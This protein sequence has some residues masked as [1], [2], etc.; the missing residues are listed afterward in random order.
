M[1]RRMTSILVVVVALAAVFWAVAS[2]LTRPA[3]LDETA[4]QKMIDADAEA[5]IP[6]EVLASLAVARLSAPAMT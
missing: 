2:Y 6:P 1:N 3:G 4:L 5:P